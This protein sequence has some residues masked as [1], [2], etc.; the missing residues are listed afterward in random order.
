MR[1]D[2]NDYSVP[3]ECIQRVLVVLATEEQV[4]I[5]EGNRVVAVH[6]RSFDRGRQIEDPQHVEALVQV[7]CEARQHRGLDRLHHAAPAS[8]KLFAEA[9]LRSTNLGGL[10]RGLVCQRSCETDPSLI[11]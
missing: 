10:T 1:F 6:E 7:K 5:P 2:F 11:V 3:A 9:A 4:R 8:H